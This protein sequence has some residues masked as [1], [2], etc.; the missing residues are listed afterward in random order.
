MKQN[1]LHYIGLVEL[2]QPKP[3]FVVD[4]MLQGNNNQFIFDKLYI[5]SK[6]EFITAKIEHYV[7][8]APTK[9]RT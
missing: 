3:P 7:T 6:P 8:G 1:K 4:K 5:Q 2:C 9:N